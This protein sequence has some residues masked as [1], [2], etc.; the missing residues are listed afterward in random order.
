MSS[1]LEATKLP[2]SYFKTIQYISAATFKTIEYICQVE[3][4]NVC[5]FCIN[6]PLH[7]LV[8][9]FQLMWIPRK[10]GQMSSLMWIFF[11]Q[12]DRQLV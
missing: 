6:I 1:C 4:K 5:Y 12:L 3:K 8:M 2:Y 7:K 10:F 11:F 9:M